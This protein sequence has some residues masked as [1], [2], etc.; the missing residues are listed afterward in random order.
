M[1]RGIRYNAVVE[2][3]GR[4]K[5][6][7]RLVKA[8]VSEEASE[9]YDSRVDGRKPKNAIPETDT[10]GRKVFRSRHRAVAGLVSIFRG[11]DQ[12]GDAFCGS[13]IGHMVI[14][15]S[16]CRG[17]HCVGSDEEERKTSHVA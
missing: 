12:A 4:G 9:G 11:L 3:E 15:C 1:A 17:W 10:C 7:V 14:H 13:Q 6:G 5:T 16:D 2:F 8:Y